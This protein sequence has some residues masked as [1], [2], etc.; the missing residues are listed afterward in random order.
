MFQTT[1]TEVKDVGTRQ[2]IQNACKGNNSSNV[3]NSSNMDNS[4]PLSFPSGDSEME[5]DEMTKVQ[6]V[7]SHT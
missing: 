3:D 5:Q 1:C 2:Y 6:F 7:L 4:R